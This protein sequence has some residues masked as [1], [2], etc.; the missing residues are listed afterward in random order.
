MKNSGKPFN[1]GKFS[2]SKGDR[3]EFKK[4]DGKEFQS[5]QGII[6]YECNGHGHLKKECPNYLRAKGKAFATTLSDFDSSNSNTEE[7][8]DSEGNYRAFMT[9]ASV[10]SK[11][12]LSKLVDDLG[13][14]SE[15]K[16]IEESE[17]EDVCQNEGEINLQEAYDSLVEDC[18][19]YAKVANLAVKNMKKVEE[20][21]KGILVQLKEAKCE[22]EGLKGKLV[23]A[24]SKINFLELEIIQANVKVE[25]I[26]TKKLDNVLSSQKS[27]HDRTGLGYTGEGSFS[28]EPKKKIRFIL[29][30][31]DEKLKEVKPEIETLAVIKRTVGANSK[32]KGISLPKNQRGPQVKHLCHHCG[33]QGH[34]RLNCF[35]FHALKKADS[36]CGQE[37]SRR[38]PRGAQARG[39]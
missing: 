12:D 39:E 26:S 36:M 23:E 5:S 21:H 18:G 6:C 34:T 17:D 27:S 1:K 22:A 14:L 28:S 10:N 37:T 13:D 4:K 3:K 33:A 20:E 32:E 8:C 19:K 38:R 2:S 24:Y 35:K 15:D 9:I 11:N 31:N 25:S 30:K 7:G 16:E 29:A